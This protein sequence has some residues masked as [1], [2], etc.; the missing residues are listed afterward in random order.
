[1]RKVKESFEE[2]RSKKKDRKQKRKNRMMRKLFA[3]K[4][5][6]SDWADWDTMFYDDLANGEGFLVTEKSTIKADGTTHITMGGTESPLFG[7]SYGDEN[8]VITK[9][10]CKCGEFKGLQWAG[11]ICPKCGYEVKARDIDIKKTAWISIAPHYIIHPYWY[12]ILM[13]LLGTKGTGKAKESVFHNITHVVERVDKNGNRFKVIPGDGVEILS[14]YTAIGIDG[15][16][17][18][19]DEIMDYFIAEKPT[20]ADELMTV[21][22][23]KMLI[24]CQHIPV[25]SPILRPKSVTADTYYYNEIDRY[26]APMYSLSEA[27]K[28]SNPIEH[29]GFQESIQEKANAIWEYNFE[30]INGKPGF[31]RHQL[32]A[33]GMDYTSRQ[34]IIPDPT[35]QINELD[36]PYQTGR[37]LFKYRIIWRVMQQMSISLEK[38]YYMWKNSF[39]FDPFIHSIM[40][41]IIAEESPRI[42]LH[43]NPTLNMYSLLRMKIRKVRTEERQLTLAVP[44]FVLD[45]MN[46]DF[47]G[48]ILNNIALV[49]DE[50]SD[51]FRKYDPLERYISSKI[52]GRIDKKYAISKGALIDLY[53]FMTFTEHESMDKDI[54][55]PDEL[56]DMVMQCKEEGDK[57][58][59]TESDNK[60]KC[61]SSTI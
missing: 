34:V 49:M 57:E 36:I 19:F 12:Q 15:F 54:D 33:G 60:L 32:V 14:P 31:I 46:A 24:F 35:L 4:V 38:A 1:M 37:I 3:K 45:G 17:E 18:K 28:H 13:N 25:Y 16:L 51:M 50:F 22:E 20:R 59:E 44:L 47:D 58:R 40:M 29:A 53:Y 39:R 11:E 52:D 10:R 55:D 21:K 43:R 48:D 30:L 26:I 7:T 2:K 42:M 56:L 41:Q 9:W 27:L 6:A 61:I 23:N 8:D 5:V